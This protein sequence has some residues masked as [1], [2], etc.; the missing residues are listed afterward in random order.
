MTI[1]LA[2]DTDVENIASFGD[3]SINRR[4]AEI[5][6]NRQEQALK[7]SVSVRMQIQQLVILFLNR[8]WQNQKTM[9]Y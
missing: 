2:A 1:E 9:S 5:A 4:M 6:L 3:V 8:L 7:V